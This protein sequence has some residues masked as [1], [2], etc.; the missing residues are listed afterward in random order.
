M[1]VLPDAPPVVVKVPIW[2][3]SVSGEEKGVVSGLGH[4]LFL[5]RLLIKPS[6]CDFY[7]RC[8]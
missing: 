4:I 5:Y 6:R 1:G 2:E 7:S 3:E 8:S